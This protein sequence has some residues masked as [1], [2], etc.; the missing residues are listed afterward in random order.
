MSNVNTTYQISTKLCYLLYN[1]TLAIP[2]PKGTLLRE[3]LRDLSIKICDD[4]RALI[5]GHRDWYR[6]TTD[7]DRIYAEIEGEDYQ[8]AV[9]VQVDPIHV[10]LDLEQGLELLRDISTMYREISSDQQYERWLEQF[11][12]IFEV[13]RDL[14]AFP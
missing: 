14:N 9:S 3:Y 2:I 7:L 4:A 13:L 8:S 1:S 12:S 11:E 5:N 10:V 6:E